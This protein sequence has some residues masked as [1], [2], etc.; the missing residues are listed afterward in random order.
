MTEKRLRMPDGVDIVGTIS[1]VPLDM[2]HGE[3]VQSMSCSN[4]DVVVVVE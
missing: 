1:M 4:D 3:V 2:G